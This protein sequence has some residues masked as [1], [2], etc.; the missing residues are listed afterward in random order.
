MDYELW[1]IPLCLNFRGCIGFW[2][3]WE[4]EDGEAFRPGD[5]EKKRR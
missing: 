2:I 4:L 1:I 3:K 5:V